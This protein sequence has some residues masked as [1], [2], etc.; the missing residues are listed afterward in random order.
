MAALR[1]AKPN[2]A[3]VREHWG[4]DAPDWVIALAVECDRT[5]Q[6]R[7]GELLGVSGAL[8]NQVLRAAY[9]MNG[10]PGRLDLFAQRVRGEL[11]KETVNCPVLR[12]I[13]ARR[14]LDEQAKPYA[15]TNPLR[16]QVYKACRAGCPNFKGRS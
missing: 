9:G 12:V 10:K 11:L 16:V 7:T 3:L 14:C 13:S 4:A 15:N 8:V 5:N 6:T 1:P 2:A